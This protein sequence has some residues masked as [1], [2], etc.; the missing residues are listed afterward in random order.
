MMRK[1]LNVKYLIYCLGIGLVLGTSVHFLHGYQVKRNAGAFLTQAYQAE[2]KGEL[3]RAADY[4]SRY[5]GLAPC[6]IDAQARYGL[7]LSDERVAKSPNARVRAL[8]VLNS[9]R[10]RDPERQDISRRAARITL[11]LQRFQDAQEAL[12][13]IR[14][15]IPDDSEVEQLLARCHEG[16]REYQQA[17]RCLENAIKLAPTQIENYERLAYL[18]RNHSDEVSHGKEE[19]KTEVLKL[20]DQTMDQMVAA[21]K[22][23]STA[24]LVRA[25]YRKGVVSSGEVTGASAGIANDLERARA[26]APNDLTV[27]LAAAEWAQ[28]QHDPQRAREYLNRARQYHP[29]DWRLYQAL[30][31]LEGLQGRTAD[32]TLC[33][34]EGLKKLPNQVE[35]LW[36]LAELLVEQRHKN[37]ALEVIARLA[38]EGTPAAELDYLRAGL[39]ANEFQWPE[40]AE[41]L[42]RIYPLLVGLPNS[43]QDWF[44][45]RLVQQTS[46]LLGRCYEHMGDPE[47]ASAAYRRLVTRAPESLAGRLGL[48]QTQRALGRL[49][50]SLDQYRQL[51]RL[52]EAPPAAWLEFARLLMERNQQYEQ[53][54]WTE[55][56]R[57]LSRASKQ[58]PPPAEAVVLRA[59]MLALQAQRQD[60]PGK[61]QE[62]FEQAHALLRKTYPDPA[63]RPV[64]VWTALAALK[65]LQGNTK[66]AFALLD[67]AERQRGDTVE[68]RLARA[69]LWGRH[70]DQDAA[71]SLDKLGQDVGKFRAEDQQRLLRGV[72]EAYAQRGALAEAQSLCQQWGVQ[73]PHSLESRIVLLDLA[74]RAGNEAAMQH[75]VQEMRRIEGQEGTLWRYGEVCRLLW[76]AENKG[77]KAVL[78]QAKTLVSEIAR[79][80]GT[81]SRV[82]L[83]EARIEDNL[84][85]PEAA[86]FNYKRALQAGEC[87]SLALR[88]T[89]ELLYERR[90]YLEAHELLRKIPRPLLFSADIR[91]V[92]AEV[93]VRV[94]D[95][96]QARTLAEK[97][98]S[99]NSQD[100][101][102]YL[103]LGQILWAAGE[104]KKAGQ[105][106]FRARD[107]ADTTPDPWVALVFYL[108]STGQKEQAVAE[109]AK[110]EQKI[111]KDQAALALA[112]CYE[113]VHSNARAQQLYQEALAAKPDDVSALQSLASF[114]VRTGKFE[115]AQPY[116]RKILADCRSQSP[117]AAAW[118]RRTLALLLTLT[119]DYQQS[120]EALALLGGEKADTSKGMSGEGAL[121]Q[122]IQAWVYA[123]QK[124]Q[125]DRRRA[126]QL[127]EQVME[128]EPATPEDQFLLAQLYETTGAWPRARKW[129]L[130][131]L[132]GKQDNVV[133]LVHFARSMLRHGEVEDAERACA[134]LQQLEPNAWSTKE[135]EVRLL[136]AK[137][138]DQ[139]AMGLL[140]L[141]ARTPGA[142]LTSLAALLEEWGRTSAAEKM[143]RRFVEQ[144]KEP[145]SILALAHFLSRHQ[146]FAEALDLC[147]RAW[148]TCPATAVARASLLILSE[149][150]DDPRL[151]QRVERRLQTALEQNP[152]TPSLLS[153]LVFLRLIQ[154]RYEEA[155][156]TCRQI[157][158][159]DGRNATAMNNLAWVL[160]F[161]EGKGS[162]ALD[163]VRRAYAL[164]G[165]RPELL[166]TRAVI[167][168]RSPPDLTDIREAIRDLEEAV[169][170]NPEPTF[171]FHL[172]QAYQ[173]VQ[174]R[175]A[176]RW[177][178]REAKVRGLKES[179]LHSQERTVYQQMLNDLAEQ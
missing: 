83:C 79:R 156:L 144:S 133:Y 48:A 25:R 15:P 175:K 97:A 107:L 134:R 56:D 132:D 160:A 100:Y 33:L 130:R 164:V 93:S 158:E 114:F 135:I 113:A 105:A 17:R 167:Y 53:A 86:L 36:S 176:A 121:N 81:W 52:P 35:L 142:A 72:A 82:P 61:K 123:L 37:E 1:N 141:L 78:G 70:P 131:L 47:R 145:E 45:G 5:L 154:G 137:G 19:T 31:K 149:A 3:T 111:P 21:N 8:L 165:P 9:V 87:D 65:D 69:G 28:D 96:Q 109:I 92:A 44:I 68:V 46:L 89:L 152:E 24:Y 125:Q 50:D 128:Q 30:A 71:R 101:R 177:A 99:S 178:L 75:Q 166:D 174:D 168:L 67:E 41:L 51:L 42:E 4:F 90:R 117:Q 88:R 74:L 173:R 120:R 29:Q 171:Y 172:A 16:K 57:A 124:D 80:R 20:A 62:C 147:D 55:V 118:A 40:A 11:S 85:N 60:D 94:Q 32:A 59:E 26:L 95:H 13:G 162:D 39:L 64:E 58:Q 38:R 54:D 126:I 129:W 136:I 148:Q 43:D 14:K 102:D 116:L 108:A 10:R 143:Y 159:K 98:V 122:R 179:S 169:A 6:D 76:R 170:Q 112:Q 157:L 106:F 103:W 63:S 22:E 2:E 155:E 7:L 104:P 146:R 151:C 153:A 140:D 27:L 77:D 127:L 161:K 84:G 139:E 91:R 18:L 73:Q 150:P 115:E 163:L 49:D 23:S 110:A 119:G 34:R 12:E 138:K 66:A